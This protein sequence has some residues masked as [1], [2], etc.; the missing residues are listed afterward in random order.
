M[1]RRVTVLPALAIEEGIKSAR[2]MFPRV[3]F[4]KDKTVRL[5]ECLKRYRRAINAHTLEPGVPLHDEFSHG[6]DC[7]RYAAM[8]VEQMANDEYGAKLNYPRLNN[9]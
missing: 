6:A 5:M 4:D 3:Y 1:G 8:A 2:M 9:S 7:F